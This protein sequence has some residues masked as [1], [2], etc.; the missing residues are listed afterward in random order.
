LVAAWE[1][2]LQPQFAGQLAPVM[3]AR[4]LFN[5]AR[6]LREEVLHEENLQSAERAVAVLEESRALLPWEAEDWRDA[7]RLL[8][9]VLRDRFDLT[10]DADELR[11]A[12]DLLREVRDH[13][14]ETDVVAASVELAACLLA[15]DTAGRA[16][17]DDAIE[18]LKA[19]APFDNL[20]AAAVAAERAYALGVAL[21]TRF[22]HGGDA[23][24]ANE[25]LQAFR[26][27][28]ALS[29]A[30]RARQRLPRPVEADARPG[31]PE[32]RAG[33][34]RAGPGQRPGSARVAAD[35]DQRRGCTYF[36]VRPF[37]RSAGPG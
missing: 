2:V 21:A 31:P 18:V 23:D 24:D 27:A 7:T 8:A 3:C 12:A 9:M 14:A 32:Q 19:A 4:V 16:G 5:L 30:G 22:G 34:I 11:Q 20:T 15:L 36:P 25:E 6:A 35:P 33:G 37:R 26:A 28:V 13:P 17:L 1:A 29:A 10:S